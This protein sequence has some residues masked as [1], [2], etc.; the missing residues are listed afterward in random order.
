M[1]FTT[2]AGRI[3]RVTPNGAVT[4]FGHG[5]TDGDAFWLA[6]GGDGA[7]WFS[8]LGTGSGEAMVGRIASS[9]AITEYPSGLQSISSFIRGGDGALWYD[10]Y[11]ADGRCLA[12]MDAAGQVT[13]FALPASDNGYP[14][15]RGTD[16]DIWSPV[17]PPPDTTGAMLRVSSSGAMTTFQLPTGD[18]VDDAVPVVAGPGGGVVHVCAG[19]DRSVS[20]R[21]Y[22]RRGPA[23]VPGSGSGR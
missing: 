19:A 12:R 8:E 6:V 14:L 11:C 7:L 20:A 16:A 23:H 17:L 9:G 22:H 3:A 4:E 5:I 13:T 15:A 18:H 1:W 21:L 2:S 10:G